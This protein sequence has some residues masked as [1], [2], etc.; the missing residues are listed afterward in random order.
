MSEDVSLGSLG[1][2]AL[3]NSIARREASAREVALAV[4]DRIRLRDGDVRAWVHIDPD[5]MLEEA[6]RL[7]RTKRKQPT[8]VLSGVPVGVKDLIDTAD[9]PTAYGAERYG[10]HQPKADAAC[11]TSLRLVGAVIAGKTVTT[12]LALWGPPPTR[13]PLRTS[14]TPGGSSAGSAAAVADFM[15]PVAL[16]TQT[17]GSVIRPASYCGVLGLVPTAGRWDRTGLKS[18]SPS[19]DRVGVF[20]RTLG[21]IRLVAAALDRAPS[22]PETGGG[23]RRRWCIGLMSDLDEAVPGLRDVLG[24]VGHVRRFDSSPLLDEGAMIHDAL[25]RRE[26]RETLRA[27]IEDPHGLSD[28][29]RRYLE[30]LHHNV[31]QIESD[32]LDRRLVAC[33]RDVHGLF[34]DCDVVLASSAAGEA[35]PATE[36]TG[37]PSLCRLWSLLG[38]PSLSLP[39]CTGKSGMPVGVHV[40]GSAGGDA[41]VI[42]VAQSIDDEVR[43]AGLLQWLR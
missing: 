10:R 24:S 4:L 30:T 16:G 36:G 8:G 9:L 37:D 42:D 15:V 39:V 18:I 38:L 43:A 5:R 28:E 6:D 33:R 34:L 41:T 21:D 12:E 35:P 29:T 2:V 23:D 32:E 13:N 26:M 3:A 31:A 1:A 25:M 27:E 11:V 20:A 22:L 17:A 40:V 19:L 7:D 14:R